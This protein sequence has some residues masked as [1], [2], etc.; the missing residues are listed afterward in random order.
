MLELRAAFRGLIRN[1]GYSVVAGLALALG[2]GANTAVFSVVDAALLRA[3]PYANEDRVVRIYNQWTGSPDASISPAEHFDYVDGTA[4]VFSAYGV[5]ATGSINLTG[6]DQPERVPAAFVSAGTLE[7]LGAAASLGRLLDE[8]DDA[9][10][11]AP[12]VLVGDGIFQRRF[13]GDPGVIGSDIVVSGVSVTVVGVLPASFRLPTGFAGDRAEIFAPLGLQ[14]SGVTARGSH[15]LAGVARLAPGVSLEQAQARLDAITERMVADWPDDYPRDMRFGAHAVPIRQDISGPVRPVLLLLL[16]AVGLVLLVVCANVASLTLT[17]ADTRRREFAVR[18]ALGASRRH[19]TRQLLAE[20]LILAL[21]G[22]AIGVLFS[23]WSTGALLAI[24]PQTIPL[25]G[26]VTL[27]ARVLAFALA[28]T[29]SAAVLFGLTP[30]LQFDRNANAALRE[31]AWGSTVGRPRQRLRSFIVAGEIALAVVLLSGAGLLVRSFISLLSVDPGYST[32]N[33]LTTRITLPGADYP[34]D[35]GR[36]EFFAAAVRR[37]AALPGVLAAGAVSNLPLANPLGDINIRVEGRE[38]RDGEVSPALD[39]Q[40]VTPGYFDA[41]GMHIVRG[42]GILDSDDERAPGAVVINEAAVNEYFRDQDPIGQRFLL[43][44][45]AGPGWVTIVGIAGDIR[46]DRIDAKPR[47]SMYLPHA[48]F[49]FWNGGAAVS[50]LSLVVSTAGDPA[51]LAPAIREAVT[52]LDPDLPT[53][54]FQTMSDVRASAF[55]W[56]RFFTTLMGAFAGLALVL[57]A[58]GTY[59]L[60]AFTVRLRTQEMGIRIAL[61]ARSEQVIGLVLRQALVPISAGLA[62]GLAA[63]LLLARGLE[64][65]LYAVGP[66]DPATLTAVVATLGTVAL[67][68]CFIPAWRAT[69][70]DPMNAMRTD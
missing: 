43:G 24:A 25:A 62:I 56:P 60:L 12:V 50:S 2:I 22:G 28:A 33:V 40:V 41:I 26:S 47:P 19:V 54:P 4:D 8:G 44:G 30:L 69:R 21:A 49:T 10:G 58:L 5:Y 32:S 27:D 18:T 3:L 42:R 65:I 70:V 66:R 68:A 29:A 15:Y 9:N 20:S 61:G 67:I 51:A 6:G 23:V 37:V 53:G 35:P 34:T 31:G 7:A 64:G 38:I 1:P 52:Q 17:R 11:G 16:G 46:H 36:R 55:S 59:G 48:Q 14:R 57:A 13:G 63:A 45:G 39:W